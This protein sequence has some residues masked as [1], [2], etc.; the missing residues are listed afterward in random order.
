MIVVF[1]DPHRNGPIIITLAAILS[2]IKHTEGSIFASIALVMVLYSDVKN[3][4]IRIKTALF[5][6]FLLVYTGK[7][8]CFTELNG[9]NYKYIG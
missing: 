1:H 8:K 3:M 2:E 5:I 9:K 7:R 4:I 6:I